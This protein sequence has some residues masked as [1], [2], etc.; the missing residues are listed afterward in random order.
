[1]YIMYIYNILEHNYLNCPGK[2][3]WGLLV[4]ISPKAQSP[5]LVTGLFAKPTSISLFVCTQIKIVLVPQN[6][7]RNT[8]KVPTCKQCVILWIPAEPLIHCLIHHLPALLA[9]SSL[10]H[11]PHA[12]NM[13]SCWTATEP[14]LHCV[15][16]IVFLQTAA[17]CGL[18]W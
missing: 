3:L 9:G 8:H 13:W 15:L 1:M 12:D 2:Q 18:V 5:I 16:P 4:K 14:L 7:Y 10:A 17:V 11:H 6:G